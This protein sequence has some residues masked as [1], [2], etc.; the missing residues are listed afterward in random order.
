MRAKRGACGGG[1]ESCSAF[2]PKTV[3]MFD[4]I[5]YNYNDILCIKMQ[6]KYLCKATPNYGG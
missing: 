1:Q 6:Y 2:F 3:D 5:L 4:H